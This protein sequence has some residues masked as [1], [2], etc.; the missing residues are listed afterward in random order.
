MSLT[1]LDQLIEELESA[2]DDDTRR[3]VFAA[4]TTVLDF[5]RDAFARVLEILRQNGREE[6]IRRFLEDPVLESI[7]RGYRLVEVD[8]EAKVRAA[9]ERLG[10]AE[11]VRLV[12]V[13]SG[14]ARL[15]AVGDPE[16]W[17]SLK[18]EVEAVLREE[19]PELVG[20]TVARRE[21][22]RE[23]TKWAP[24]LH[25]YE[26]ER[27]GRQKVPFF[28]EEII[29]C[30]LSGRAHAFKN[31]CPAGGGSLDQALF[32]GF[33]MTCPCHGYG[34][35]MRSG[36]GMKQPGLRLDILPVR[37]EDGVVKVEL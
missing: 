31:R 24:L 25:W 2:E 7:L 19:V 14:V 18:K 17:M 34:F 29:V 5:Q 11:T 13:Q 8:L 6:I 12:V 22:P 33:V 15:E 26:L 20:L 4:V 9:L 37:V 30:A 21:T 10:R 36:H 16:A 3:K 1:Q 32:E 35:D 28:E 23:A 27:D